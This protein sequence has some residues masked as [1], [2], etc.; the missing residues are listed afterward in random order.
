MATRVTTVSYRYNSKTQEYVPKG[1]VVQVTEEVSK[2]AADLAQ[3]QEREALKAKFEEQE[4]DSAPE[5]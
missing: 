1:M 5:G 2:E 3:A 4:A